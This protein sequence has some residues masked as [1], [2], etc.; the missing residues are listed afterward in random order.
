MDSM[1]KNWAGNL[2]YQATRLCTPTTIEEVQDVVRGSRR[3]KAL[4]SRHSFSEVADTQGDLISVANLDRIET[5]QGDRV[6]VQAGIRYGNLCRELH[7]KGKAIPNLASL[8]HIS[9]GGAIATATHGSGDGNGNLATA[10]RALEFVLADGSLRRF[11]RGG[12]GFDGA[13]VHLGALGVLIRLEL[14]L[15]PAFPIWQT[16]YENLPYADLAVHFDEI[17]SAAY[18]VSLFTHWQGEVIDQVWV[19]SRTGETSERFFGATR[20]TRKLHPIRDVPPENCSEQLGAPGPWFERL[21]H[22][23]M[24]FT[25]SHGEELQSE[26]LVPRQ[27][28][29]LAIEEVRKLSGQIAPL[30]LIS[31]IR[32][33]AADSLWMSP[34]YQEPGVGIHFTWKPLWPQVR[35]VLPRIESAL[36]PFGAKPHWGKLSTLDPAVLNALYPRFGD[37]A[38]LVAEADPEGKFR[39]R[40]LDRLLS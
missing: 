34:C 31:E 4:G 12:P 17:T 39:N 40:F 37:F 24:E 10:V 3:A 25:P 11:E 32:T 27:N 30:L 7:A 1:L 5:I 28:A 6:V 26:F 2:S 21:P 23:K 16:V 35:E 29:L 18:S 36:A 13:V 38:A 8:P 15:Q 22:F 20:A 19:K 9:V 14:D 33:I